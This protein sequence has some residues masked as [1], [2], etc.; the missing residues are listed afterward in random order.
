M[1]FVELIVQADMH[2]NILLHAIRNA[3]MVKVFIWIT[4][5]GE[6]S[7]ILVFETVTSIV[8]WL[9]RE[10]LQIFALWL[11]ILASE[12]FTLI[13]KIIFNRPRPIG[14]VLLESTNSFPSG[15]ATI[16]VAFYGFITYLLLKKIKSK[17]YYF[18]IIFVAILIIG[19]IGFSRLYLGV[20]YISDVLAGYLVG[21]VWLIIGIRFL[22]RKPSKLKIG[23]KC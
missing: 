20:H 5:L 19:A 2:F 9:T 17:F 10:K 4:L 1:Q 6:A 15:H 22:D 8:I 14:A 7:T 16:A 11:T 13:A 12:C 18:F 23:L 3:L 21:S